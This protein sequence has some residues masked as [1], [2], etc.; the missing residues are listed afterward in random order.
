MQ[1]LLLA[2]ERELV[3]V[4]REVAGVALCIGLHLPVAL[5]EDQNGAFRDIEGDGRLAAGV[6]ADS[7]PKGAQAVGEAG[8]KEG[9]VFRDFVGGER[10]RVDRAD[11]AVVGDNQV[12]NEIVQMIMWIAGDRRV[13]KVGRPVRSV[14]ELDGWPRR[15]VCE[16][17]PGDLA[18]LRALRSRMP[19]SGVAEIL[20]GVAQRVVARGVNGVA[21][22]LPL[23]LGGRELGR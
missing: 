7:H 5:G 13:E 11:P 12:R 10:F 8:L 19:L 1:D 20:S 15:V 22:H 9:A 14:L 16:R 6:E 21:D 17:H 23:R 2:L 18:G 3:P 4:H